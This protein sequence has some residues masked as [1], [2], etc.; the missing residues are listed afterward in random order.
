LALP[1]TQINT[2]PTAAHLALCELF[3]PRI[4]GVDNNS[5]PGIENHF[6]IHTVFDSKEFY[7]S[8]Y[9]EDEA[10]IRRKWPRHHY[11]QRHI[12]LEIVQMDQLAPGGEHVAYF[13]TFW[14]RIVQRRWKKVFKARKELW[15]KR[16]SIKALQ[17]K[18]RTGHW[19]VG[20]RKVPVFHLFI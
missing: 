15:L 13:K 9:K 1:S 5:T 20:L 17:E 19:P 10:N 11:N 14:L 2:M 7:A 16:S 12:R 8:S 4:H 6:L 3:C 18:Q